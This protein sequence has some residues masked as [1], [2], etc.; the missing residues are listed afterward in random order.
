[1]DVREKRPQ[2]RGLT[3]IEIILVIAAIAVIVGLS[4][5]LF[6][7]F[8]VSND[9]D[10]TAALLAQTLRRAQTHTASG[11]SGGPWGVRVGT[12]T[13]TLFQ[14]ADYA[15]RD[16]SLDQ[17]F[18]LPVTINASG[19][20]ETVF[21]G[22]SGF[23]EEAS[24]TTLKI[25]SGRQKTILVNAKGRVVVLEEVIEPPKIPPT[26][27]DYL[28]VDTSGLVIYPTFNLLAWGHTL[29][30]STTT[31]I[32]MDELRV[33]WTGS[34]ATAFRGTY[35]F[36]S[37][38]YFNGGGVPSGTTVDLTDTIIAPGGPYAPNYLYWNANITGM[39]LDLVYIMSDGSE[40]E[41][42]GITF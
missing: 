27:A 21:T 26:E 38:R 8:Q 36:G 4:T 29:S 39:T 3:L 30:N 18:P 31:N 22:R 7:I 9:L 2:N 42:T 12:S 35:M 37:W 34:A 16:Q 32:T 11:D 40:Y 19:S 14:G 17:P 6:Q 13:F 1:M 28:T 10:D 25:A 24:T 33:T 23:P 20:V 41:I 5:P 15:S